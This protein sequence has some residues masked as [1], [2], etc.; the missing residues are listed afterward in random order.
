MERFGALVVEMQG[1]VPRAHTPSVTLTR[2][3]APHL[4]SLSDKPEVSGFCP[5]EASLVIFVFFFLLQ[6]QRG[7]SGW[8]HHGGH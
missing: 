6:I 7:W 3:S 8:G 2:L 4:F 1:E 5:L